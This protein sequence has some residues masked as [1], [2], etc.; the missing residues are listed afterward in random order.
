MLDRLRALDTCAVSDA[1]DT[2]NLAG[3]NIYYY[4]TTNIMGTLTLAGG[5]I[6]QL[7]TAVNNTI[8]FNQSG[9]AGS[10]DGVARTAMR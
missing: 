3:K 7:G 2:L 5:Q 10:S 1:L 6:L 4:G 9:I 8:S